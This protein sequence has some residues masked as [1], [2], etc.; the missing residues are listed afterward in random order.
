[1]DEN[2]KKEKGNMKSQGIMGKKQRENGEIKSKSGEESR[3]R[4]KS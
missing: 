1:M 3:E 2:G 4:E